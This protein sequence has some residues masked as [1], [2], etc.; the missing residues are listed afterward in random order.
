[1]PG[2]K[3]IFEGNIVDIH[4]RQ[5][6]F[7][8]F[9]VENGCI[10]TMSELGP[11]SEVAPFFLPGFIDAHIH[12]ESSM[13]VPSE[14]ARI[15]VVHGTVATVSDPHEI[16]NVLGIEGVEYMIANGKQTPFKFFFGA[17]SCVPASAF[18]TAGDVID[19][20]GIKKLM[21]R[22]DIYYLSEMMN[23]PGVLFRDKEVLKKL[24]I[25]KETGKPIDGHA[26][27]LKG[28]DAETYINAGIS[29]DHECVSLD[30]ALHKLG[31]GMKVIIREGSAAKNFETLHTLIST[32]TEMVMFCSDDKHPDDLVVGHIDALVRRALQKGHDLFDVLQIACLNPVDHYH[33][34]IGL[35][36]IHDAADFIKVR[37]LHKFE[38]EECWIAGRLLASSGET[39]IPSTHVE[40]INKFEVGYTSPAQFDLT[41]ITSRARIIK[42]IGGSLLTEQYITSIDKDHLVD[43]GRD[44]LKI[45]VI[46]RYHET[47]PAI[48][49]INGFGLTRGAIASC[50]GH[51]SHNIIAVGADNTSL[52]M[53]VNLVIK[54]RGGISLV[55]GD[56]EMILPLPVAGIM[57]DRD[58]WSVASAYSKLNSYVKTRMGSELEAPYMTLSFM[59][60]LVIPSL[61]LSDLGLFDGEVF[62]FVSLF[63]EDAE[64]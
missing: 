28:K 7:G 52:S 11:Q 4:N 6:Y 57:S 59:A 25:A 64:E 27:G 38:I 20:A 22:E 40:T 18:E 61:K 56:V 53:A 32:H 21:Q 62:K 63:V 23:Y 8:R 43:T 30:E 5:I 45:A 29:T 58:A 33:L 31:C 35:L 10:K 3:K 17:P 60:L 13:L 41:A 55:D 24:E 39:L 49:L 1:M 36:R 44:I 9:T 15:A 50:V 54:N 19:A 51:D 14:F 16:A 48:A 34:P 42:A 12:I 26:P 37:S 47:E 46:N 2:Q